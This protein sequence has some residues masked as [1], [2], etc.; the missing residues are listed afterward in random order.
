MLY[1]MFNSF[2]T[3]RT[4]VCILGIFLLLAT[5]YD[6][7]CQIKGKNPKEFNGKLRVIQTARILFSE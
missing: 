1:W 4:F 6:Y 7:M 5:V 2:F 3:H